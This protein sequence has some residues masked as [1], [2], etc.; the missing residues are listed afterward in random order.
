MGT[1]MTCT[2][3]CQYSGAAVAH[4][5]HWST[6]AITKTPATDSRTQAVPPLLIVHQV[7]GEIH[8]NIHVEQI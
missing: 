3:T 4:E 1:T 2:A 8:A 7:V 5:T 6:H